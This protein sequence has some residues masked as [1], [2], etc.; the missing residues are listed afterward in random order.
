VIVIDVVKLRTMEF[1][2]LKNIKQQ[3]I[4]QVRGFVLNNKDE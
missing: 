4:I 3:A 2:T 1:I